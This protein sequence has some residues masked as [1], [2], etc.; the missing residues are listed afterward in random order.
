MAGHPSTGL[1]VLL[2]VLC[3]AIA[4]YLYLAWHQRRR[5]WSRWRVAAALAGGGLLALG[6][7]PDLLP[8][9]PGDFRQHMLQHLLLGMLGPLGLMLSAPVTLL[10]RSLPRAA[11]RA[12]VRLLHS[13]YMR[14]VSHPAVA[15]VL[16]IGGMGALYFTPLY[17]VTMQHPLLHDFVHLHFILAGYLFAWVIAGPDP[18]PRRPP[19]PTRLVVLGIAIACHAILAQL[20][21]AG[22]LVAVDVPAAE[23]RGGAE[24]MYYGGD[25]AE[26][27]LA[28]ALVTT[29]RPP[30]PAVR[31]VTLRT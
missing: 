25:I 5:G 23:L 29:W 24:L 18:A 26:L 28:F 4:V 12:V 11:A 20:M 27:L 10:L 22:A 13:R 21:Y 19:V 8:F 14:C 3:V 9:A 30:R 1:H 7:L 31:P 17:R 6:L 2:A 16:N 15:L